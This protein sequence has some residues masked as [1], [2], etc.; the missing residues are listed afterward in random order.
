MPL[1]RT[2]S[3]DATVDAEERRPLLPGAAKVPVNGAQSPPELGKPD[4]APSMRIILP[5]LMVCAFL[6]AFDLTVVAAI[7]P[8]MFGPG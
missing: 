3:N 7:Y 2:L 6:A 4:D 8:I 1:E 5:A